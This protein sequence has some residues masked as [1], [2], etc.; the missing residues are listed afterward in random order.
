MNVFTHHLLDELAT[1]ATANPRGRAH[2]NIHTSSADLVQRF[3]VVTDRQSYFRPHR[4]QTKS[5]LAVVLRGQFEILTFDDHGV[6]TARYTIG[7]DTDGF[8]YETPS[9]VWHTLLAHTDGSTFLE[10]KEGPYDP[11]TAAQ[12]ATWA[13]AEGDAS[14]PPFRQWLRGAKVGDVAPVIGSP[15]TCGPPSSQ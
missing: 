14:V 7:G 4:H 11:A 8:A 3:L 15:K 6:V 2:H 5:E 10:I 9:A 12:F 13:P 1:K